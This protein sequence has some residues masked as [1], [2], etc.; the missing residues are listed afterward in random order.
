MKKN[1]LTILTLVLLSMLSVI[2]SGVSASTPKLYID[3]VTSTADVGASFSINIK[4]ADVS[5]LFTWGTRLQW[6]STLLNVTKVTEGPFLKGRP[7]GTSMIR[8]I[9]NTG[10]YVDLSVTILGDI[11][12]IDGS[13]VLA[14]VEFKAKAMG[15]TEL[16]F[17]EP[18]LINHFL[19]HIT[20]FDVVSGYF[21]NSPTAHDIAV[22]GLNTNT[23]LVQAGETVSIE[24]IVLNQGAFLET[25]NLTAYYTSTQIANRTGISLDSGQN[26]TQTFVWNTA[27][28]E[29]GNYT[30]SAVASF[31]PK[32][33][34]IADNTKKVYV[35]IPWHDVAVT[36]IKASTQSVNAIT[37]AG[38]TMRA[39]SE[40][41]FS[42]STT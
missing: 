29:Q 30:I 2:G 40:M 18:R 14:T 21:I 28:L 6:N 7:L 10:G 8:K 34:D 16:E 4:I 33:I 37:P 25:F 9:N 31:V 26:T 19:F 3:P 17:Y 11:Q 1:V 41:S 38:F 22:I 13:G 20:P 15:E 12:G 36:E 23:T 42:L 39:A 32:E 5:D 24:V 27:G 35:I